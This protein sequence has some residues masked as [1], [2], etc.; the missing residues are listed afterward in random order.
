M[1]V[2]PYSSQNTDPG[3]RVVSGRRSGKGWSDAAAKIL[4]VFG[5]DSTALVKLRNHAIGKQGTHIF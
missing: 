1:L 5:G 2:Q 3:G 4:G